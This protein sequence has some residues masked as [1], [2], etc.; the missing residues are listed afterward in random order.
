MEHGNVNQEQPDMMQDSSSSGIAQSEGLVQGPVQ[1]ANMGN[2]NM[3]INRAILPKINMPLDHQLRLS[4]LAGKF[5]GPEL[6]PSFFWDQSARVIIP[7]V[8]TARI[9]RSVPVTVLSNVFKNKRTWEIAF[10]MAVRKFSYQDKR[11]EE[12]N[13]ISIQRRPIA[14][15]LFSEPM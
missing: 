11:N 12:R 7:V 10:D 9:P 6:P 3:I 14:R 8:L 15:A 4:G 5:V 2:V 1:H 13:L